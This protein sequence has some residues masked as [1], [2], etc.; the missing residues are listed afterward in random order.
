MARGGRRTIESK[1]GRWWIE[2]VVV[3]DV[4]VKRK[5]KMMEMKEGESWVR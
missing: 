5:K 1:R 3:V 2:V 4:M